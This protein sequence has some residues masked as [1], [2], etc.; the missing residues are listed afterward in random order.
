MYIL[1]EQGQGTI[2]TFIGT[3]AQRQFY[4]LPLCC[5]NLP[6]AYSL[7]AVRICLAGP[8]DKFINW[9][10]WYGCTWVKLYETWNK[11]ILIMFTNNVKDASQFTFFFIWRNEWNKVGLISVPSPKKC[12]K[13]LSTL[14]SREYAQDSDL[15]HFLEV[16]PK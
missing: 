7:S 1:L 9:I 6:V 16:E 14:S 11:R 4:R 3:Q 15:A 10:N 5:Q 12:A 13:S 8:E 2:S